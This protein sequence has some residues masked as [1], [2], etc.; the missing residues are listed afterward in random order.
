[1]LVGYFIKAAASNQGFW[2][3]NLELEVL[4]LKKIASRGSS[5]L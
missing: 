4:Q 5:I 1:V 3:P 2:T